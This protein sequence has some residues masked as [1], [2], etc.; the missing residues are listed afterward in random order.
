MER[1][2]QEYVLPKLVECYSTT[3]F[4]LWMSSFQGTHFGLAFSKH[5]NM[6]QQKKTIENFKYVSIK[7]TQS[8]LQKC[9][10]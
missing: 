3:S 5:A 4:Y 1:I 7:A 10:I 6:G 2:K 8:N 9:I